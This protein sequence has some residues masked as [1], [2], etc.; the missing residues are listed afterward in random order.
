M[1][2]L[3][4]SGE[5]EPRGKCSLK[6]AC[7]LPM[8]FTP[9]GAYG[10]PPPRGP[11]T[12][13]ARLRLPQQAPLGSHVPLS[14]VPPATRARCLRPI[15]SPCRAARPQLSCPR[16]SW[17]FIPEGG[18]R[19]GEPADMFR[20]WA[21][22]G[23]QPESQLLRIPTWQALFGARGA[24]AGRG[25]LGSGRLASP[26]AAPSRSRAQCHSPP[27]LSLQQ[28]FLRCHRARSGRRREVGARREAPGTVRRCPREG[29]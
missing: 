8:S 28:P 17:L 22:P 14:W 2:R 27:G 19:R 16:Q 26:P 10:S 9:G 1:G 3:P 25:G 20:H 11:P 4:P 6:P 12:A 24:A 21:W 5:E 23:A 18:L 15:R 29:A 13:P 7:G